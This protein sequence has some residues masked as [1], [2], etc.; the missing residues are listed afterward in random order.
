M[1]TEPTNPVAPTAAAANP[2]VPGVS[3]AVEAE[4]AEA[5]ADPGPLANPTGDPAKAASVRE[6]TWRDAELRNPPLRLLNAV[7]AGLRRLR[8]DRPALSPEKVVVAAGPGP[9]AVRG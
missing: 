7:G 3:P 8:L 4:T 2:A 1:A 9:R 6:Y 5:A